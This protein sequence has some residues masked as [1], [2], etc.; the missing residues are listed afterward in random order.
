MGE[1]CSL[2]KI[3]HILEPE[4]FYKYLYC[5][6]DLLTTMEIATKESVLQEVFGYSSFR[7]NQGQIIDKVLSGKDTLVIMPTGGGKSLCYQVPALVLDGLTVVISPL[8]ALMMDQ[9]AALK[10]NGVAAEAINSNLSLE[11]RQAIHGDINAG[12]IKLLY[13]S[14]E[15][16]GSDGF[17][18]FLASL[19]VRLFAIDEAHCVSTWGNDFRPDYVKLKV[20]KQQ[21]PQ[22]PIVA[23]TA[24]A[25]STTQDDII[26]Q[27]GLAQPEKFVSSFER[28]NITL[29]AKPGKNRVGEILDF[30]DDHQD[31][32]GIIYC[33]SRKGTETLAEKLSDQGL[34]VDYYHAGRSADERNAVQQKFQADEI[35]I[36]C[37]TIAFGM[38][39]DKP[40]IRWVIHYNMPKNLEGYYQE[41][42]RAGRDGGAA[43]ALLF[44]SWGDMSQLMRFVNES[45]AN[46]H[47]KYI[48][49]AKLERMW[50]FANAASCRTNFILNYFGE[51][52]TE[53]CGHCDNCLRPPK[54]IEGSTYA[55][56]AISGVIRT[57]ESLNS[58]LLMDLLKGSYKQEAKDLGLP[59]IK[60]FGAGRKLSYPEWTSYLNQ[61]INQ[62]ILRVDFKDK[63]RIKTT[64]LS[65]SVLND[66][67]TIDLAAHKKYE[68]T[69]K[70][71]STS[72]SD[73]DNLVYD[74]ALFEQFRSWRLELAKEM[75][76]PPYIIL[77]DKTMKLICAELPQNEKEL[78][79]IEGIGKGKLETYGEAI[80]LMV[81]G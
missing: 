15:K 60:T 61:M 63:S 32:A 48:Q 80:L 51:Y 56:M 13:V 71:T 76:M 44:Y 77:N 57:R 41:I 18:R 33:L 66:E 5:G 2:L 7:L 53:G 40:N 67:L 31:E 49:S 27:L 34:Q 42:G 11:Q 16:L 12:I 20:I 38:G 78:L 3:D 22:I 37:A 28:E 73:M 45:D 35:D 58:G 79:A 39:I 69:D 10:Q 65:L 30:I 52:R 23:L 62:G 36:I 9:V 29:H 21:F 64:P 8:I 4:T 54:Y 74:A 25:D 6:E 47:F 19:D 68:K 26:V 70:K 46:Q 24:T 43:T 50:Q 1:V 81:R 72:K 14:P 59:N 17:I 55:K 75:K